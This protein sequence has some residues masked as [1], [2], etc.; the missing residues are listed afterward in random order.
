[1]VQKGAWEGGGRVGAGGSRSCLGSGGGR[2]DVVQMTPGW[3][4]GVC[5]CVCLRGPGLPGACGVGTRGRRGRGHARPFLGTSYPR[6]ETP[7]LVG[8]QPQSEKPWPEVCSCSTS[9]HEF[10][11]PSLHQW[12]AGLVWEW[13]S[14]ESLG[15]FWGGRA[16]GDWDA[17]CVS[18]PRQPPPVRLGSQGDEQKAPPS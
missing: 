18:R 5:E 13:G 2:G 3:W 6:S 12:Q 14:T 10:S 7:D 4:V 8:Q 16:K 15:G 1:M 17:S 11:S 9:G